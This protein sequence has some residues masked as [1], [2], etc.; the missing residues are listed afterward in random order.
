MTQINGI[1]SPIAVY[2][3]QNYGERKKGGRFGV[4]NGGGHFVKGGRFGVENGGGHIVD[5]GR[6]KNSD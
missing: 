2:V 3:A 1:R 4:E 6:E 5:S